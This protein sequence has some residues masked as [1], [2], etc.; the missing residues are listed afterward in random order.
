MNMG[1]E[2][3]EQD[4]EQSDA[5]TIRD[6]WLE[7]F[8]SR[9]DR[10]HFNERFRT[11]LIRIF[12]EYREEGCDG[13]YNTSRKLVAKKQLAHLNVPAKQ[14]DE[15]DPV[16]MERLVVAHKRY[17]VIVK[18][19]AQRERERDR[20]DIFDSVPLFIFLMRDLLTNEQD[21]VI[22][23]E[24]LITA[25]K[26]AYSPYELMRRATCKDVHGA[27]KFID[28]IEKRMAAKVTS[29]LA[30]WCHDAFPVEAEK[31]ELPKEAM[32]GEWVGK[33]ELAYSL[34]QLEPDTID[35]DYSNLF[36]VQDRIRYLE[37]LIDDGQVFDFRSDERVEDGYYVLREAADGR[38]F[39]QHID[40]CDYWGSGI[41]LELLEDEEMIAAI[42]DTGISPIFLTEKEIQ[43]SGLAA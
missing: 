24:P 1:I 36:E 42:L 14:G 43:E 17:Q 11:S 5:P 37:S 21:R 20:K 12:D 2:K 29:E 35:L 32:T 18:V 22:D 28:Y 39:Q 13:V 3:E 4:R 30:Q 8:L 31:Y 27:G 41:G 34:E 33:V 38:Y 9:I 19:L 7:D 10:G 25:L 16:A 26:L 40:R 23:D 6:M 15:Y